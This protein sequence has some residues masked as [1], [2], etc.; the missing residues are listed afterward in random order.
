M[1]WAYYLPYVGKY[2]HITGANTGWKKP[3]IITSYS[4]IDFSLWHEYQY[5]TSVAWK[6]PLFWS[7]ELIVYCFFYV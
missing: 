4:P 5:G 2:Q 1:V 3:I 7:V 6:H